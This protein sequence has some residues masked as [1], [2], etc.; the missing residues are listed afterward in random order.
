MAVFVSF[1]FIYFFQSLHLPL[2]KQ[3]RQIRVFFFNSSFSS[4][5]FLPSAYDPEIRHLP[6]GV[7]PVLF[8]FRSGKC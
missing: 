1:H 8:H 7:R 2:T 6:A 3:K 5:P 4:L